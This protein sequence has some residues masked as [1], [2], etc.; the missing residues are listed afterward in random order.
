M[1]G[2]R[3]AYQQAMNIGAQAAWDQDWDRAIE[4]YRRAIKEFPEDPAAY[5]SIGLAHLQA[6]QLQEALET[7]TRAHRLAPNDPIPLERSADVYERMGK[8][9]NAAQNYVKV[10]EILLS[11]RDVK[12]AIGNW[13]R[14]TRLSPGMLDIHS[15]LALAYERTGRRKS[16]IREYLTI[17]ALFQ[18]R[19][20]TGRA[21]QA[22]KRALRLDK[23]NPQVLNAMQALQVGH[24]VRVKQEKA[25]PKLSRE[26]IT[27]FEGGSVL[28]AAAEKPKEK[29]TTEADL[30]GPI[31][32]AQERALADLAT[33]LFESGIATQQSGMFAAQAI[34]MQRAG[35]LGAAI[36]AYQRAGEAGLS[37]PAF[38]L[39]LGSLLVEYGDYEAGI[40]ILKGALRERNLAAGA[41]FATAQAYMALDNQRETIRNLL[42]T[43]KLVDMA[44]S[45]ASP[46]DDRIYEGMLRSAAQMAEDRMSALNQSLLA[47]MTGPEWR[48]NVAQTRAQLREAAELD[49]EATLL[50]MLAT[51]QTGRIAAI[52][53]R[54]DSYR[55]Q[56]L[57]SLAMDEAQYAIQLT[58][59]YLPA[60]IRIAEILFSA[61]RV[62]PAI[63]KYNM[64]AETYRVRGDNQKATEILSQ[65]LEMAPMDVTVRKK[66]LQWLEE[67]ERWLDMFDEYISLADTYYQLADWDNAR[68]TY[69][70]AE[71]ISEKAGAPTD[72]IVHILLRLADIDV[73][74]LEM[75]SAMEIYQRIKKI[76]P[77]DDR[78]RRILIDIHYRLG[79][80]ANALSELDNLLRLYAKQRQIDK[81]AEVLEELVTMHPDEMG[82]RSRLAR[83]YQQQ[84]RLADAVRQLDALGELQLEAGLRDEAIQTIRTIIAMNPPDRQ[85]YEQLLRQ[86][87]Q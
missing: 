55:K 65:L 44:D 74:R 23:N 11:K 21:I 20:D 47:F 73:Q 82:L 1:P 52:M 34:D 37:H 27:A 10:A 43:L 67:E 38:A 30:K 61:N 48:K 18:R 5:V 58:P 19:G 8:L 24:Q 63:Q 9:E 39:N 50:E 76:A 62:R 66:R 68:V 28:A 56:G 4:A 84:R 26:Q 7:Y 51:D 29:E 70:Q 16:A 22:C 83:V 49:G 57:H 81:I 42:S 79:N 85:S 2:D 41:Y 25:K 31:G 15:R 64:V 75:R 60:H 69:R 35:E 17:A 32:E 87:N 3:D 12:K 80:S 14:A 46:N 53:S 78:T 13:E 40:D 54:I 77:E 6:G 36:A 86:L 71:A 72:K 45:A 33:Y 59:L